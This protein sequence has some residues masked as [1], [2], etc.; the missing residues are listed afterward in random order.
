MNFRKVLMSLGI[1]IVMFF[2]FLYMIFSKEEEEE[3]TF[4]EQN[5]RR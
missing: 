1:T 3:L 5:L 2:L 4:P